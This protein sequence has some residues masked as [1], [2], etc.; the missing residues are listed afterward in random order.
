MK[1][2]RQVLVY[3]EAN[4]FILVEDEGV[5]YGAIINHAPGEWLTLHQT[6]HEVYTYLPTVYPGPISAMRALIQEHS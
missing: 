6:W 5:C 4:L 2:N 3:K 1:T